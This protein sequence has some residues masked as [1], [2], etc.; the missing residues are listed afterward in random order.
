MAL[1]QRRREPRHR[2]ARPRPAAHARD[3]RLVDVD[4]GDLRVGLGALAQREPRVVAHRLELGDQRMRSAPKASRRA[5]TATIGTPTAQR[6]A[7]PTARAIRAA[8]GLAN[9]SAPA[10]QP[11]RGEAGERERGA[12]RGRR[13][14]ARGSSSA[15]VAFGHRDVCGIGHRGRER[16]VAG[17]ARRDRDRSG[18]V[19]RDRRERRPRLRR[20]A[21]RRGRAIPSA[22]A[23]S[24]R[25]A[26]SCRRPRSRR[27]RRP[28]PRRARATAPRASP[29][30]TGAG[31][32]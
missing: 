8:S 25:A 22:R 28:P 16:A 11:D 32:P 12:A 21:P 4:D 30:A 14:R 13:R 27:G 24:R 23:R 19:G 1:E 20:S 15:S 10:P 3:A 6:G 18:D 7:L 5:R 2:V 29:S 31:C 9:A 26:R 17:V